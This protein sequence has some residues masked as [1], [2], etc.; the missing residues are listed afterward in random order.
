MKKSANVLADKI[1]KELAS[2]SRWIPVSYVCPFTYH[3]DNLLT[4]IFVVICDSNFNFLT[5][6]FF[7]LVDLGDIYRQYRRAMGTKGKV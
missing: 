2:K 7:Y 1:E 4:T 5:T 3:T 6:F